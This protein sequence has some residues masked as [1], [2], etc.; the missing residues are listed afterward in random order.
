MT[1]LSE[2]TWGQPGAGLPFGVKVVDKEESRQIPESRQDEAQSP[3]SRSIFC[4]PTSPTEPIRVEEML[5]KA[6][7]RYLSIIKQVEGR[8]SLPNNYKTRT[9]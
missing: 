2:K 7:L 4:L 8:K 6:A 9:Q 1:H 5:M 3:L